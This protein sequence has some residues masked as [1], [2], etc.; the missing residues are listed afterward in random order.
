MALT[1]PSLPSGFPFP[2]QIP[3][4]PGLAPHS[5]CAPSGIVGYG[6]SEID[7]FE[8]FA[9]LV[10]VIENDAVLND[11]VRVAHIVERA[12]VVAIDGTGIH[13]VVDS[14]QSHTDALWIAVGKRPETA[15]S[16]SVFGTDTRMHHESS[17]RWNGEDA[18]LQESLAP[19]DHDVRLILPDEL[20]R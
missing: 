7:L 11:S 2:R 5:R 10:E 8:L 17:V 18:F 6:I 16:I 4:E 3:S 9:E 13:T 12:R 15:V 1:P 20:H 19:R 14:Q